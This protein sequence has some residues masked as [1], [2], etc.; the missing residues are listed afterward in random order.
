MSATGE[1]M[2]A[3]ENT[4]APR[5]RRYASLAVGAF[6]GNETA[7]WF[8]GS[9][10]AETVT[11]PHSD[12]FYQV[13]S[14]TKVFTAML[15][16]ELAM[17]GVVSLGTPLNSLMPVANPA[18]RAREITL[19]HAA[20]HTTGLPRLPPGLRRSAI[21]HLSNPYRDYEVADLH[22]AFEAVTLRRQAGT[23]YKY[24]N[25]G[26]ALLG[27]ALSRASSAPY[28]DLVRNRIALPLGLTDTDVF[29]A[30]EEEYRRAVGHSKPGRVVDDWTMS[31]MAPA[32]ALWSTLDDML[33]LVRAHVAP[34]TTALPEVL[35]QVQEPAF[36]ASRWLHMGLAWH[37]SPL[38]GTDLS[39]IWHNGA[40]GGFSSFVAFEPQTGAGV[41]ALTN[42]ARQVMPLGHKVLQAL[43]R[44]A[45]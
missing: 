24:S 28:A 6:V 45:K 43:V 1:V 20:T 3:L 15:L 22:R 14:V 23:K 34:E 37:I 11:P 41:V 12:T 26:A 29:V 5:A 2:T 44:I 10:S 40:T 36:Q 39:A 16:A 19:K 42:T 30:P 7:T 13:G 32:G 4:Y 18:P 9:R 33:R 25:F 38:R 17:R 27:D 21:G 35:R 31:G 8:A